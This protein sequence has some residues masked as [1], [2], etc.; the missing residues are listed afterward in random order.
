M[1]ETYSLQQIGQLFLDNSTK[2]SIEKAYNEVGFFRRAID[3]RRSAVANMPFELS[4]GNTLIANE[5]NLNQTTLD[6]VIDLFDK[7][8]QLATDLDLYG[9]AYAI[10]LSDSL[11]LTGKGWVRIHPRRVIPMY[12]SNGEVAHWQIQTMQ[13]TLNIPVDARYFLHLWQPNY[14]SYRGPGKSIANAA[15]T[16]AGVLY[17]GTQFQSIYFENG[18]LM[19]TLV[20]IKGFDKQS[21]KQKAE[22]RTIFRQ[23]FSKLKNAHN[24]HPVD[25]ETTVNTLQ[26]SLRDMAMTELNR[27]QKE[28]VAATLG[29]PL[30]LIMSNASNYATATQ[31]DFNFYDKAIS[32]FL[33]EVLAPQLNDLLFNP[34]GYSLT[35]NPT[36]LDAYQAIEL[37]K[38]VTL[39]GMLDRNVI[40]INEYRQSMGFEPKPMTLLEE[41]TED[42]ALDN[43][44]KLWRKMAVKRYLEGK[45]DKALLFS[46]TVIP[47][48]L[49]DK[50]K[51]ALRA[52][53]TVDSVKM[54]FQDAR[55]Y[56]A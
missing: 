50:I 1:P 31:D 44:L 18:A 13:R 17:Y 49:V 42:V 7:I 12:G 33:K 9:A 40:D 28:T 32:P 34:L 29:V 22:I 2:L 3:I 43:E 38:S 30:S 23:L 4:N 41:P 11:G 56:N 21:P 24:I 14:T 55:L 19:P 15:L 25:G 36:R 6:L 45:P 26:S 20:S 37:Q 46:T 27:E 10:F 52:V 39:N 16:S 51:T 35:Y 47:D 48:V 5:Q 8:P 54:I 53:E